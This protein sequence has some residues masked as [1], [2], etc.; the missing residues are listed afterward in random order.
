[1]RV[2]ERNVD[3]LLRTCAADGQKPGQNLGKLFQKRYSRALIAEAVSVIVTFDLGRE[4]IRGLSG[5][6]PDL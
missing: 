2:S 1:M 5:D 6:C 3:E 4:P